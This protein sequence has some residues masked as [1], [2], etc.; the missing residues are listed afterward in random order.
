MVDRR[1]RIKAAAP[2]LRGLGDELRELPWQIMVNVIARSTLVPSLARVVL[3]R[4]AGLDVALA[5]SARPGI[6]IRGKRLRVEG[7]TTLNADCLIDARAPVTIGRDCGIAY[8]VRLIT[9]THLADDP[10]RRAGDEH[11]EPI[12]IGHGVWIGSG[13]TVLPGVTIGDGAV[14]AAGAVVN[15][16]CSPHSLYGGIPA[17]QLRALPT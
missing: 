8:G 10:G 7:G 14:V 15:Q 4:L 2:L 12:T 3:Y 6:R 11:V 9:A 1:V 5:A 13:A 16:D 17:R